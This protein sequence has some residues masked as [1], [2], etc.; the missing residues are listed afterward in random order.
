MRLLTTDTLLSL[1]VLTNVTKW[2]GFA[3]L[4][5]LGF[6]AEKCHPTREF[7]GELYQGD[8]SVILVSATGTTTGD[9]SRQAWLELF[10]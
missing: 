2:T 5:L 3:N 4:G 10:G 6:G 9:N 8:Q 1:G 7:A